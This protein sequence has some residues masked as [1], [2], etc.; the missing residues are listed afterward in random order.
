MA[1]KLYSEEDV[2][3]GAIS[4]MAGN[5]EGENFLLYVGGEH[6]QGILDGAPALYWPE[7]WGTRTLLYVWDDSAISPVLNALQNP[8]WRV[9]EM[10]ARVVAARGIPAA[11]ELLELLRDDTPR[12]RIAG[13]KAL[14]VVGTMENVDSLKPLLKDPNVEVRRGA[15]QGIE[16]LRS[17]FPR[18]SPTGS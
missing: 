16:A 11:D 8:A 6:A 13:A 7:L 18:S 3:D 1:V 4:L 15:R 2:V 9:R 14:G 5:N 10:A 12:V 17:R